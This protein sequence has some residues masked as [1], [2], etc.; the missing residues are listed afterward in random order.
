MSGEMWKVRWQIDKK[1]EENKIFPV[2]DHKNHKKLLEIE[3]LLGT[4]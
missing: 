2:Q 4:K 1:Q 3:V